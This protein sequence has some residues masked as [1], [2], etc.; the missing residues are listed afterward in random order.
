MNINY[1]FSAVVGVLSREVGGKII[2]E[3]LL[4]TL[5]QFK[6]NS[7]YDFHILSNALSD[8][9]PSIKKC[10]ENELFKKGGFDHYMD[11]GGFQLAQGTM[12]VKN[13][14]DAKNISLTAQ[15]DYGDYGFCFDY[16]PSDNRNTNRKQF[17]D[18]I[19]KT[20]KEVLMHLKLFKEKQTK[21]KIFPIL[22][23]PT[24]MVEETLPM[25][26]DGIS[27]EDRNRHLQGLSYNRVYNAQNNFRH[28]EKMLAFKDGIIKEGLNPHIHV[29]AL[30]S[31]KYFIFLYLLKS[32]NP[33]FFKGVTL[34]FDASTVCWSLARWGMVIYR[35]EQFAIKENME[36]SKQWA[37]KF[38]DFAYQ[39][40]DTYD[41][42]AFIKDEKNVVLF[43][44]DNIAKGVPGTDSNLFIP[45]VSI[46]LISNF[47]EES[48]QMPEYIEWEK[49]KCTPYQLDLLKEL[50][51]IDNHKDFV[52]WFT[53]DKI[54]AF[55][56]P[57]NHNFKY[58]SNT[59]DSFF[60]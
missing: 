55:N 37:N 46:F 41:E 11:S 52:K 1:I 51:F 2:G 6:N 5:T 25:L 58:A 31:L 18:N 47:L 24:D 56:L 42:F 39:V 50:A 22:H 15:A 3:T 13:H 33:N 40:S 12:V 17:L 35:F 23:C 19:E 54:Q 20:N 34:S 14:T 43:E 45:L 7:I 59:L 48:L 30:F 16:Q 57:R 10:F 27:S 38:K 53:I 29:L 49:N 60:G 44:L 21:C 8:P 32:F 26:L 9:I 36:Q 28:F 4:P